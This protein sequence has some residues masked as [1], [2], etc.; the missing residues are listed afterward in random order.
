VVA[1]YPFLG[2]AAGSISGLAFNFTSSKWLVFR[3]H[4]NS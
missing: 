3:M 2:V 1:A 4:K